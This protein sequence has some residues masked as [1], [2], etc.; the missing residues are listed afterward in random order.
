MN[1][2]LTVA[3]REFLAVVLTRS[4]ALGILLPPVMM[5]IVITLMPAL[6]NQKPPKVQGHVAVIDHSGV[7]ADAL[8]KA[9]TLESMEARREQEHKAIAEATSKAIGVDAKTAEQ[10]TKGASLPGAQ[11]DLPTLSVKVLPPDTDPEAAKADMRANADK[12]LSDMGP[13][14][15]LALVIIPKASVDGEPDADNSQAHA[16]TYPDFPIFT[17]PRL[18]PEV[19]KDIRNETG[20]AIVDARLRSSGLD[21]SKVRQLTA[22]PDADVHVVTAS[23]ERKGNEA[24]QILVPGAFMFLMWISVFTAGQ[25][26]LTST[27][28]E[29]SSRVMEVL[30]SAVSPIQLL[31]GKIIGKGAVG[32]LVLTLY[33]FTGML[34]L[35]AFA[36]M[37]LVPWQNLIYLVVYFAIAYFSI[38]AIMTAV[39]SAVTEVAE[40]QS[41]MSPI[42]LIL[43][44]PMMLWFPILRNPNSTF[45]Q[46][47]SFVPFINPFVM[48]LRISGSE[49]IPAWQ[50]PASMLV[51]AAGVCLAVWAASKVF[52]IGV[53]M[54]GKPPNLATLVRWVRMA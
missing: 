27:I 28:E 38:S 4:F 37:D 20:R 13:D 49:P 45:A 2:I 53:L 12:R 33:A 10:A 8:V 54:Y 41:L 16:T 5:G 50:I 30:L 51:G 25:Y 39:G 26:L 40:A 7:V 14:P 11:P 43:V 6:M 22:R 21:A 46:V 34:A 17:S 32:M 52:R 9:F 29:K 23:G 44:I 48:V 31:A 15:R 1:K 18:D 3:L 19:T 47:C 36:M 42:M 24:A 35:V